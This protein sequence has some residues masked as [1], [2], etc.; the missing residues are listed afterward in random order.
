[1]AWGALA[2]KQ[3]GALRMVTAFSGLGVLRNFDGATS[4]TMPQRYDRALANDPASTWEHHVFEPDVVVVALG[5]NDF[6]GGK[7]DPGPGFAAAYTNMLAAVREAHPAARIV[8]TTSPMLGA[9]NYAKHRAY[10]EASIAARGSAGDTKI[11][12]VDIDE[13]SEADGYGCGYHPSVSTHRKM[14]ARLVAHV[15]SLMGW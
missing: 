4:E 9:F 3:L 15:K 14:A 1:M 11:T 2:A 6:A 8:T 7:G 10:V 12:L 5:T 13:Q